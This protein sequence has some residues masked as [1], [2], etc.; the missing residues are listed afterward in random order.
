[1]NH[2]QANEAISDILFSLQTFTLH[3]KWA[4]NFYYPQQSTCLK[5]ESYIWVYIFSNSATDIGFSSFSV[6][7]WGLAVTQVWKYIIQNFQFRLK[8]R[9]M[10]NGSTYCVGFSGLLK[11]SLQA[12]EW[13]VEPLNPLPSLQIFSACWIVIWCLYLQA[14]R[15][16][17]NGARSCWHSSG[18]L[19]SISW[20]NFHCYRETESALQPPLFPSDLV[21]R[22]EVYCV[23]RIREEMM[24]VRCRS[25]LL[26]AEVGSLGCGQKEEGK[27]FPKKKAFSFFSLPWTA[28]GQIHRRKQ[29]GKPAQTSADICL[30]TFYTAGWQNFSLSW[31][32]RVKC[33]IATCEGLKKKKN[34]QGVQIWG[35]QEAD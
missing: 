31:W 32:L 13:N 1:M 12:I 14:G 5:R 10:H 20:L 11:H 9:N 33:D 19:L 2:F 17:G 3:L 8:T 16:P 18:H 26:R 4:A 7:P 25:W 15:T 24:R 22:G 27:K 28:I 6:K 34:M 23:R 29:V 30:T 21:P 35:F